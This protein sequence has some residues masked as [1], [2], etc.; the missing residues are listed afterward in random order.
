[1]S[2]FHLIGQSFDEDDRPS[3]FQLIIEDHVK[4]VNPKSYGI[5]EEHINPRDYFVTSGDAIQK[6]KVLEKDLWRLASYLRQKVIERMMAE[7]KISVSKARERYK[8]GKGPVK[9]KKLREYEKAIWVAAG[10][11]RKLINKL[12]K[13]KGEACFFETEWDDHRLLCIPKNPRR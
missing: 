13:A 7:S 8:K 1:M 5:R 4:F 9:P 2:D 11:A 6:T 10:Q 12:E 3:V